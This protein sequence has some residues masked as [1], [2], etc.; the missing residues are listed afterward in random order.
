MSRRRFIAA[1]AVLAVAP[2]A[3]AQQE[4]LARIGLLWLA[5]PEVAH[6]RQALV[7]GLRARGY[8]E[9]RNLVIDDATVDDYG[10]LESAAQRLVKRGV[11]IIVTWGYPALI[12]ARG[13]SRTTPIL[14]NSGID[15]VKAGVA[16]SLARPAGNV[17]GILTIN[18]ELL[19]KQV[20]LIRETLPRARRVLALADATSGVQTG[21]FAMVEPE[22]RRIGL[23][24]RRVEVH[25]AKDLAPAF[26]DAARER[27]HAVYVLPSTMLQ[28]L[29]SR[30][31][32]L[33]LKY[34]LPSF[35]YAAEYAARGVLLTYG[36]DRTAIFRR[37]ADYAARILKGTA[38]GDLP[39]ERPAEFE[40]VLNLK[41]A[42]TLGIA[43]PPAVFVRTTRTIE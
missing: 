34:R 14:M 40:L 8:V 4:R 27:L 2:R 3:G 18:D 33:A 10:K 37:L 38:P 23:E 43:I 26:A 32:D 6:L 36:V 29:G 31:G 17:T 22:A 7:D 12:A 9:G 5:S 42:R 24:F 25:G 20:Q 13:A 11:E 19:G 16:A 39:I 35:A 28:G 41:T 21:Y 30:I 1:C 15:P